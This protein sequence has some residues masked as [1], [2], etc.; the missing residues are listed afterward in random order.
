MDVQGD[1][2]VAIPTRDLL[3]VTGSQN[4]EGINKMKEMARQGV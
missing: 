4:P 1:I 3:L 2:V